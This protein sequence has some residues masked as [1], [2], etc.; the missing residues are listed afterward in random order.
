[1]LR[2]PLT[3][4]AAHPDQVVGGEAQECLVRPLGGL[5]H[6]P[7]LAQSR[8]RLQPAEGSSRFL[9]FSEVW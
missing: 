8:H 6:Q 1:M 2:I 3:E 5:I 4:Q 7:R 9:T